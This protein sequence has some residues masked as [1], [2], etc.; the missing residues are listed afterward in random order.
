[1]QSQPWVR[2]TLSL[3][4]GCH[5]PENFVRVC[6]ARTVPTRP[7][8]IARVELGA[9]QSRF[10]LLSRHGGTVFA[11]RELQHDAVSVF[12]EAQR[13]LVALHGEL[14]AILRTDR[15]LY[16]QHRIESLE[17][18]VCCDSIRELIREI[19]RGLTSAEPGN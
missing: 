8:H 2:R 4:S 14:I 3:R 12:V 10:N 13:K 5:R 19:E 11:W 18:S 1:M 17:L 9:L 16:Q 7:S 15:E 6:V